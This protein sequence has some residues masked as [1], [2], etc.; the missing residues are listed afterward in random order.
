MRAVVQRVSSASVS[1]DG[2][3][4]GRC[5]K[6]LLALVGAHKDDTDLSAAKLA[7]RI[8][9]M[10]IFDDGEGKMNLA[11]RDVEAS[12]AQVLAISNFTVFGDAMKSRR[13]SFMESA[14]YEEAEKLFEKFVSELRGREIDVQTGVFGE[15]MQVELCNDGPVTLV[16]D[17]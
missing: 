17:C 14:P 11:L 8:A 4:V 10:R 2:E 15:M 1:V 12:G 9:G 6:G 5:G 13:P 3:V 7:D 16:I